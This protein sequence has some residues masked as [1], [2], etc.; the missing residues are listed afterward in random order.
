MTALLVHVGYI[1]MLFALVTRDILWLRATL[2]LAQSVLAL[3]AWSIGIPSIAAW[4]AMFVLINIV[5]V[6]TIL[7][8][9]RAVRLP[10]HLRPLYERHFFAL[11]QAEFL[12]WWRLGRR[13]TVF[14]VKMASHGTFPDSLY[15]MLDG[16]ARVSRGDLHV[17]DLTAGHF[18]AEMS[19][20]TGKPAN[21]DVIAMGTADVMRWRVKDLKD[22]R[23]R[24]ASMWAR[25]QSVIGHDLVLKIQRVEPYLPHTAGA[26]AA[27]GV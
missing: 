25:I 17:T 14:D 15:F 18:V 8:E 9:R 3:Y 12:R 5:W 27:G 21:A 24:D 26:V 2:V 13:E 6:I 10:Q 7:R 16:T 22:L 11:S 20:I 1:L 23:E 19:L 4:N